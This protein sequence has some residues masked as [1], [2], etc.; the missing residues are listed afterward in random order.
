MR[1]QELEKLPQRDTELLAEIDSL[2]KRNAELHDQLYTA[3]PA[4]EPQRSP[5]PPPP[6]LTKEIETNANEKSLPTAQL[7]P[8]SLPRS[9][10]EDNMKSDEHES[11]LPESESYRELVQRSFFRG[12]Y[13]STLQDE[14]RSPAPPSPP[15]ESPG[16]AKLAEPT[17]Q[18]SPTPKSHNKAKRKQLQDRARESVDSMTVQVDGRPPDPQDAYVPNTDRASNSSLEVNSPSPPLSIVKTSVIKGWTN[19]LRGKK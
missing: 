8:R 16:L 19:K 3:N 11:Q 17:S 15:R 7:L 2:W 1:I 10:T 18:F 5:P 9:R 6:R 12:Q 4:S 13:Q 14:R